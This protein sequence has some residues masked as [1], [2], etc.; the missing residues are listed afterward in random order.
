MRLLCLS[1]LA[2]VCV[3]LACPKTEKE[4]LEIIHAVNRRPG[5]TEDSEEPWAVPTNWLSDADVC[6]WS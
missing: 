1:V 5:W 4:V 3:C 6:D 2:L